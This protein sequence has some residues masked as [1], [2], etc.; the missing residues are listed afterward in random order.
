MIKI[1]CYIASIL[2]LILAAILIIND[3]WLI[4]LTQ[5]EISVLALGYG[6]LFDR[7]EKI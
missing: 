7:I 1:P 5:L 3:Q 4:G 6:D 2:A